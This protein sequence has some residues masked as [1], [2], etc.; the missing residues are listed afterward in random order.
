MKRISMAEQTLRKQQER[1]TAEL[2][3]MGTQMGLLEMAR[4]TLRTQLE[5]LEKEEES[6]RVKR[7]NASRG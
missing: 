2:D 1:V 3:A 6:L 7:M 4:A 5:A